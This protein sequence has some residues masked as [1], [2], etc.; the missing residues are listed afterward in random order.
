L[1]DPTT[2]V[3]ELVENAAFHDGTPFDADAVKFNLDRARTDPRS[4]VKADIAT[5]RAVEVGGKY[6]VILRLDRPNAA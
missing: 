3:M 6:R 5:V 1:E 4:N 2:F